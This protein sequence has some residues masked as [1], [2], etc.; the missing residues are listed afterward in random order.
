MERFV[1]LA[2]YLGADGAFCVL[3]VIEQVLDF[4]VG[5]GEFGT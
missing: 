3:A 5:F 4:A 1:M 2:N